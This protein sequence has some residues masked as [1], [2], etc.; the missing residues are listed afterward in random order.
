MWYEI[1]PPVSGRG[2]V[3]CFCLPVCVVGVGSPR[4]DCSFPSLRG[5]GTMPDSGTLRVPCHRMK[6]RYTPTSAESSCMPI[7]WYFPFTSCRPLVLY[8]REIT[9][10]LF[11]LGCASSAATWSIFAK[12]F[13]LF[14][15]FPQSLK[16]FKPLVMFE[17][18]PIS[19]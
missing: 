16:T 18:Y 9:P 4:M 12:G 3:G 6:S 10:F 8:P 5:P 14:G 19:I 11:L 15:C 13:R 2:Y 17:V 7:L 1:I